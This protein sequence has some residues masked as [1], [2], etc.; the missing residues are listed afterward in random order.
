LIKGEGFKTGDFF[1]N[2]RV[3][4]AGSRFTPPINESIVII[5]KEE[6]LARIEKVISKK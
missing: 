4:I 5:G 6:T 3:A 2:L 1:M